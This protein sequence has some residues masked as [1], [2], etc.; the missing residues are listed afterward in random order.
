MPFVV[1]SSKDR[2]PCLRLNPKRTLLV[3]TGLTMSRA[4]SA[5]TGLF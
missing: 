5:W 2:R 4:F 1:F 3:A